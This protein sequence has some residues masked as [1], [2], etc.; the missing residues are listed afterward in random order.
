MEISKTSWGIILALVVIL[1]IIVLSLDAT[2]SQD[3]LRIRN[4]E[5]GAALSAVVGV[6]IGGWLITLTACLLLAHLQQV[7]VR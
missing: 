2:D 1:E 4:G 7:I 6:T 3:S 5:D